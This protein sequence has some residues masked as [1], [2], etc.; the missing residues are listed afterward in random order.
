M[1]RPEGAHGSQNSPAST[2]A[3]PQRAEA[4]LDAESDDGGEGEEEISSEEE[5]A[6][7]EENGLGVEDGAAADDCC[8]VLEKLFA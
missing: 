1:G 6:A 4:S 3:S 8:P 7:V 5:T 2:F